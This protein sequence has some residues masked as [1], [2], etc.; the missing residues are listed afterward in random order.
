MIHFLLG[1]LADFQ[2]RFHDVSFRMFQG[3]FQLREG[4]FQLQQG[5][6]QLQLVTGLLG[7]S[8]PIHHYNENSIGSHRIG[9]YLFFF[10]GLPFLGSRVPNDQV[11]SGPK[12]NLCWKLEAIPIPRHPGPLG[13]WE[14]MIG[15]P[16]PPQKTHRS[17]QEV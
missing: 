5:E 6:F 11:R 7:H 16:R 10:G 15:L 17:P 3:E 2:G 12:K 1:F 14:D 8:H 4:E 13:H 9:S